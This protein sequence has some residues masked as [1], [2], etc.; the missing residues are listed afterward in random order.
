MGQTLK[1]KI[2]N[3]NS[4]IIELENADNNA[5]LDL[6]LIIIPVKFGWVSEE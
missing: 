4:K 5:Q 1:I 6:V 3:N 2:I